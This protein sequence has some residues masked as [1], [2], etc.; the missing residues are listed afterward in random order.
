MSTYPLA[1]VSKVN[2]LTLYFCSVMT[3]CIK[4]DSVKEDHINQI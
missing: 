2:V 4:K 1:F 3:V